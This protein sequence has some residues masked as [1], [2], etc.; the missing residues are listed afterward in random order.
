MIDRKAMQI[1]KEY[2]SWNLH[3]TSFSNLEKDGN[4]AYRLEFPPDLGVMYNIFHVSVLKKYVHDL[5]HVVN[6]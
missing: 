1:I 4:M 3:F 2:Q 5:E 6:N